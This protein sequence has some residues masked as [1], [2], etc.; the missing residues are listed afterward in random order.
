MARPID[1]DEALAPARFVRLPKDIDT[2]IERMAADEDRPMSR[3]FR[4]L[5]RE[6]LVAR[7]LLP[8]KATR[9]KRVG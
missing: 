3:V 1:G 6:A 2:L 4:T 9:I 5:L 7:G 8:G